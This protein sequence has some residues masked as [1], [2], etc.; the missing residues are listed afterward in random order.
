MA[1]PTPV[2]LPGFPGTVTISTYNLPTCVKTDGT[3]STTFTTDDF[4]YQSGE[5][6]IDVGSQCDAGG[7]YA[8]NFDTNCFPGTNN[9]N[10]CKGKVLSANAY[11]G[12]PDDTGKLVLQ[13]CGGLY[14]T[15]E[16]VTAEMV[17]S[18]P[19]KMKIIPYTLGAITAQPTTIGP[20]LDALKVEVVGSGSMLGGPSI[21]NGIPQ[22]AGVFLATD[23][24][25]TATQ[26]HYLLAVYDYT[27]VKMALM[28]I[29]VLN[30]VATVYR[31]PGGGYFQPPTQLTELNGFNVNSGYANRVP[32]DLYEVVSLGV[33]VTE[34]DPTTSSTTTTT[35][36]P[37]PTLVGG[38]PRRLERRQDGGGYFFGQT[39]ELIARFNS[40]GLPLY[41]SRLIKLILGRNIV[42]RT[43]NGN[44]AQLVRQNQNVTMV[45]SAAG[46]SAVG[47]L[48]PIA[49]NTVFTYTPGSTEVHM[50]FVP[51]MK[52][53]DNA[54]NY[55]TDAFLSTDDF[56]SISDYTF[57]ATF[58]VY[59][60]QASAAGQRR[61]RLL[62]RD[63]QIPSSRVGRSSSVDSSVTT[64]FTSYQS[65][66]PIKVSQ[67]QTQTT[68]TATTSSSSNDTVLMA[69]AITLGVLALLT[70]CCTIGVFCWPKKKRDSSASNADHDAFLA[71]SSY[72]RLG[73]DMMAS[74]SKMPDAYS[75]LSTS[76]V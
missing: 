48:K 9:V 41:E 51:N 2:T 4:C 3:N 74:S 65:E 72:A 40:P 13:L 44:T 66:A 20:A 56:D 75:R 45:E 62:T 59:F 43:P 23:Y 15:A 12:S 58:R 68:V 73:N 10:S 5:L 37:T 28:R 38:K 60:D 33:T 6:V 63:V 57:Y 49:E 54:G 71:T 27:L 25:Q 29:E 47:A 36:T 55:P 21:A 39:V 53:R 31:V 26:R 11:I 1:Q 76:A 64:S 7:V 35:T 69:V 67:Q 46:P 32:Y 34:I 42:L 14:A 61:R 52:P 8:F 18:I 22:P 19:S 30:G 24:P 17:A 16:S 70:A 50:S